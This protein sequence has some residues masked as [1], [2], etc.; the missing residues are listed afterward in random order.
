MLKKTTTSRSFPAYDYCEGF[1][2]KIGGKFGAS[3]QNLNVVVSE[4][5]N[6]EKAEECRAKYTSTSSSEP[7][8]V[9]Q[10]EHS[11]VINRDESVC[12]VPKDLDLVGIEDAK[13]KVSIAAK[14]WDLADFTKKNNEMAAFKR[15]GSYAEAM[16][17]RVDLSDDETGLCYKK[18]IPKTTIVEFDKK[19]LDAIS[20]SIHSINSISIADAHLSNIYNTPPPIQSSNKRNVVSTPNLVMNA[21]EQE[22]FIEMMIDEERRRSVQDLPRDVPRKSSLV[23]HSTSTSCVSDVEEKTL[24]Y[25]SG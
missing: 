18:K 3:C 8:L 4:W 16:R 5:V 17:N 13:E 14:N 19:V 23:N 25:E 24:N 21:Q 11:S 15:E 7:N 22:R 1:K 12:S 9:L 20:E 10:G 6:L 2:N